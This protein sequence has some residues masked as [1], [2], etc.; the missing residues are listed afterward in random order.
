MSPAPSPPWLQLLGAPRLH[1]P[2]GTTH[3]LPNN[4]P[5]F[6][7]AWLAAHGDWVGREALGLVFWPDMPAAQVLLNLRVNL[8]RLRDWLETHGLGPTLQAERR[9]VRLVLGADVADFRAACGAGEWGRAL[10]LYRGELLHGASLAGLAGV[11]AWQQAEREALRST[12]RAVLLREAERRGRAGELSAALAL[13]GSAVDDDPLAEPPLLALVHLAARLP[14]GHPA[15]ADAVDRVR[16]RALAVADEPGLASSPALEAAI[17]ALRGRG[18]AAAH[19]G[20]VTGPAA[21]DGGDAPAVDE[22]GAAAAASGSADAP[23]PWQDRAPPPWVGRDLDWARLAALRSGDVELVVVT[24][25]PGVGKTRLLHE[26]MPESPGRVLWLRCRPGLQSVPLLAVAE[27]LRRE[28]PRLQAL[29]GADAL[30][31]E[32]ARLLPALAPDETLAPPQGTSAALLTALAHVLPRLAEALV[33]DDLQWCDIATRQ[34]LGLLAGTAPMR[35]WA[36]LRSA[37]ADPALRDWLGAEEAAGRCGR[38]QLQPWSEAGGAELVARLSGRPAPRFAKWLHQRCG[39]NP[40]FVLETLRLLFDQGR[41]RLDADGWASDLDALGDDYRQLTVPDRVAAVLGQRLARLGEPSQRLLEAAAVA[42]SAAALPALAAV[43]GLPLRPAA[44]ALAEAQA[45]GLMQGEDFAH[46]LVRETVLAGLAAPVLRLLHAGVVQHLGAQ[47]PPHVVAEHAWAAGDEPAAVAATLQA[48][49]ANRL[50]GLVDSTQDL[51]RRAIARAVASRG[52]CALLAELA[53]C[54][55]TAGDPAAAAAH[56]AAALELDG[57]ASD[58]ASAL[59]TQMGL[60]I[61]RSDHAEAHRVLQRLRAAHPDWPDRFTLPA[62]LAHAEGDFGTALELM[63]QQVAWLR[64]EPGLPPADLASALSG[65][66]VALDALDR[67]AEAAPLHLEALEVAERARARFIQVHATANWLHRYAGPPD[68]ALR[69]GEVALALGEYSDT[70]R[71]RLQLAARYAEAERWADARRHLEPVC[72]SPRAVY[73]AFARARLV[74]VE[75]ASGDDARRNTAID[76]AF[77]A[78]A[79]CDDPRAKAIVA[80]CVLL[81]GDAADAAR[82]QALLARESADL[83]ERLDSTL[84]QRLLAGLQRHGLAAPAAP[85]RG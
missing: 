19:T 11:D 83:L 65:L 82:A 57:D 16:R 32:L 81:D 31:R 52:R 17:Q 38:L 2:D 25:E 1:L 69:A 49:R 41:L 72:R 34:L 61:Q 10:A 26:F 15:R 12:W 21:D 22:A 27:A 47:L 58:H 79:A 75:A 35:L 45:A 80:A 78:A 44:Q 14:P 30:R 48:S 85:P 68:E 24:G 67:T 6:L 64:R 40:L 54:A 18:T 3:E 74:T 60:A 5:G 39:G 42:G 23:S 71:L 7:A 84:R 70:D 53:E 33:V 9:R 28:L 29:A 50:L 43:A 66:A 8:H 63:Q 46:D 76:E 55:D 4:L 59:G 51:L 56:A 37:E 36:T 13:A 77:A 73:V 20:G 62:K